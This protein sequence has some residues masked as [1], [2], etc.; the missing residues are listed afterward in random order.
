MTAFLLSR[1]T[2][3]GLQAGH[4]ARFLG[5]M[6]ARLTDH[7]ACHHST[8]PPFSRYTSETGIAESTSVV[9]YDASMTNGAGRTPGDRFSSLLSSLSPGCLPWDCFQFALARVTSR[10]DG[11]RG[12]V[13]EEFRVGWEQPPYFFFLN[14]RFA[15]AERF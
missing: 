6:N 11:M 7:A 9:N 10:A 4:T 15:Q 3:P 2:R 1:G 12:Q 5:G 14:W 8:E 13:G